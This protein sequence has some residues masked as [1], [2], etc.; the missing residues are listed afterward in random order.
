MQ[1][2]NELK[3]DIANI[4]FIL[5]IFN[6]IGFLTSTFTSIFCILIL[7]FHETIQLKIVC[8]LI[9]ILNTSAQYVGN[10][11]FDQDR[12]IELKV[13]LKKKTQELKSKELE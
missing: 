1:R 7:I 10:Q 8:L 6:V 4:E 12:L 11:F 13:E 3:E 2:I 9:A 5:K